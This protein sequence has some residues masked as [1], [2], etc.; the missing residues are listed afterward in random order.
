[1][2]HTLSR[3]RITWRTRLCIEKLLK[4]LAALIWQRDACTLVLAVE[5]R[6][7]P[8]NQDRAGRLVAAIGDLFQDVMAIYHPHGIAGDVAGPSSNTQLEFQ[9]LWRK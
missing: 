1:M 8:N 3:F 4:I 5:A 7:G 2:K 6:E 9:Q